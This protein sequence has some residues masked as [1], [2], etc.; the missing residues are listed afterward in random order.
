MKFNFFIVAGRPLPVI[1]LS[2]LM[3]KHVTSVRNTTTVLILKCISEIFPID[4]FNSF[5]LKLLIS[6]SKFSATEKFS[7]RYQTSTSRYLELTVYEVFPILDL[8]LL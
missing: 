8:G 1:I 6:Q 5:C 4:T 7:L 2:D 3:A